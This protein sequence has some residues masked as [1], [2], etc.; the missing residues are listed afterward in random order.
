MAKRCQTPSRSYGEQLEVIY[1]PKLLEKNELKCI[2]S[3]RS[4]QLVVR[5]PKSSMT[6]K[7]YNEMVYTFNKIFEDDVTQKDVFGE[8]ARPMLKELLLNENR[9]NGLLFAYGTTGSGK[10]YTICGTESFPGI[11]PRSLDYVFRSCSSQLIGGDLFTPV[12][13]TAA[14]NCYEFNLERLTN[15]GL[16]DVNE[17][18]MDS[19]ENKKFSL[20]PF[21]L[22]DEETI[23]Q[24]KIKLDFN[25]M[26]REDNLPKD[27]FYAIFVS[28]IE[29]YNEYV[30]DLLDEDVGTSSNG[31][32]KSKKLRQDSSGS[33]F[34]KDLYEVGP[35]QSTAEALDYYEKGLLRRRKSYTSMNNDSS[36]SH[37]VFR[38]SIVSVCG[39]VDGI[40]SFNSNNNSISVEIDQKIQHS[41][42]AIVDL[43]GCERSEKIISN[44][45]HQLIDVKKRVNET[46]KIN[47]SLMTLRKCIDSLRYNQNILQSA[48]Q[49][50]IMSNKNETKLL[51]V[52]YRDS[53]LTKLFKGHFEGL[54]PIRMILCVNPSVEMVD[55]NIHVLNFARLAQVV[56]SQH[57]DNPITP[58]PNDKNRRF[59]SNNNYQLATPSR[60]RNYNN[61]N[62][63]HHSTNKRCQTPV[64]TPTKNRIKSSSRCISSPVG[65]ERKKINVK[66]TKLH[67]P[68]LPNEL[69][70]FK[71]YGR[72]K[73]SMNSV[74]SL[75]SSTT[76]AYS[77]NSS[78]NNSMSNDDGEKCQKLTEEW[79]NY[80]TKINRKEFLKKQSNNSIGIRNDIEFVIKNYRNLYNVYRDNRRELKECHEQL[81]EKNSHI[82]QLTTTITELQSKITIMHDLVHDIEKEKENNL[83]IATENIEKEKEMLENRRRIIDNRERSII[84]KENENLKK[85]RKKSSN[86]QIDSISNKNHSNQIERITSNSNHKPQ[87]DQLESFFKNKDVVQTTVVPMPDQI[88]IT[89][90]N[91]RTKKKGRRSSVPHQLNSSLTKQ[92]KRCVADVVKFFEHTANDDHVPTRRRGRQKKRSIYQQHQKKIHHPERSNNLRL[93]TENKNESIQKWINHCPLRIPSSNQL[94]QS[95]INDNG[96]TVSSSKLEKQLLSG[97]STNYCLTKQ[98]CRE[99]GTIVTQLVKGNVRKSVSGGANV[100]FDSVEK[101]CTGP[102]EADTSRDEYR[103]Q[104]RS[105]SIDN[106]L[107]RNR[108]R[109]SLEGHKDRT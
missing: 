84:R 17:F 63:H 91:N 49:T 21:L 88:P 92:E 23:V 14:G 75:T 30:Y 55:E 4:T 69:C 45:H 81:K 104:N 65:S 90:S 10:T 86:I 9:R 59:Q 71:E 28:F 66:E 5:P 43:A 68:Q 15:E 40:D 12:E 82:N 67:F 79:I 56:K 44:N 39:E 77:T 11:I 76:S 85:K 62:N 83:I 53:V 58:T 105:L 78:N 7:K 35:L 38:I 109:I 57:I 16:I 47:K 87:S 106:D 70:L 96:R 29:V 98:H 80:L 103:R 64:K 24:S 108:C 48:P 95:Q 41:H 26:V 19:S 89:T 13:S 6:G 100:V 25:E 61:N 52:P 51:I 32:L 97:T 74:N 18:A 31:G 93:T 107:I 101:L 1:R 50:P 46:N 3:E 36:R 8:I 60:Y 99:N 27:Q 34:V 20:G 42:L 2:R 102:L 37:S 33:M 94:F 73:K 22:A 72:N 54:N